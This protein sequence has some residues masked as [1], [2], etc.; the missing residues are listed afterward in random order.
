MEQLG[1]KPLARA[2]IVG[3]VKDVLPETQVGLLVASRPWPLLA[4]H[5][6]RIREEG[7]PALLG[8]YLARLNDDTSFKEASGTAA[9]GRLVDAALNPLTTPPS[10]RPA[11]AS[12]VRIRVSA[13]AARSRSATTPAAAAPGQQAPDSRPRRRPRSPP[14]RQQAGPA[15]GTGRTR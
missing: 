3:L 14:P 12:P 1:V 13:A 15:R 4:A 10:E 6:N 5:M 2:T 11:P 8:A 9:V 7:G